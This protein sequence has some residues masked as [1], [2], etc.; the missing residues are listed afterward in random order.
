MLHFLEIMETEISE[1]VHEKPT[2]AEMVASMAVWKNH[3]RTVI[4][5]LKQTEV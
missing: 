2:K 3:T 5:I 1:V 4:N